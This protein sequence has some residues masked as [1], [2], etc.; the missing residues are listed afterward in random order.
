MKRNGKSNLEHQAHDGSSDAPD[1]SS[2][3][4]TY[5]VDQ[6][7]IL[8][9]V[10]VV[11]VN[12]EKTYIVDRKRKKLRNIR[13]LSEVLHLDQRQ[14]GRRAD[15]S[16]EILE[17]YKADGPGGKAVVIDSSPSWLEQLEKR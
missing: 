17:R 5:Y 15:R 1:I 7:L 11:T 14:S 8:G 9:D 3:I 4:V 13:D 2:H 10:E 12:G 6:F 16:L